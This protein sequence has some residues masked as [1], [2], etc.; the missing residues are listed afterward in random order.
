VLCAVSDTGFDELTTLTRLV[1]R[2]GAPIARE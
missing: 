1:Q 2:A